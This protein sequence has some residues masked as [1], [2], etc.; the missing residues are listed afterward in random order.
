MKIF[1]P[2]S[3]FG[4]AHLLILAC[5][6]REAVKKLPERGA[7]LTAVGAFEGI[8][9]DAAKAEKLREQR[10]KNE[11]EKASYAVYNTAI[12]VTHMDLT[13]VA[14]GLGTCWIGMFDKEKVREILGLDERYGIV[15]FLQIGYA[16]QDP[17]PRPRLSLDDTILQRI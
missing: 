5:Y 2:L 3:F 15:C 14:R 4:E 8:T 16:L 10:A 17:L 13:A 6:D 7:E 9:M 1:S 12:S 11:V